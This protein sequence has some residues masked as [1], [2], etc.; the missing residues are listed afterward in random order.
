MPNGPSLPEQS[1]VDRASP[2]VRAPEE[3]ESSVEA[4]AQALEQLSERQDT[5]LEDAEEASSPAPV[6]TTPVTDAPSSA[7]P[8]PPTSQKD[9]VFHAVE[10]I[11]E[12]GLGE[13]YL[14]LPES[15]K[16]RFHQKGEEVT[17]Q[18]AAMV[19]EFRVKV[20]QVVLL[21]REWL[22]TIPGVN[23]FF[24]EQEAKIKTDRILGL[25][26]ARRQESSPTA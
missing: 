4:D 15:A 13:Y 20:K 7:P 12:D 2:E 9:D 8:Q 11:L 17:N 6:A 25:A 22:L 3:A 16:V 23:K 26:Y 19:R 24:L 5:F 14:Q 21:I 10:K 1:I 18:I